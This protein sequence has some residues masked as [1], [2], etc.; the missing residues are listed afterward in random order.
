MIDRPLFLAGLNFSSRLPSTLTAKSSA[1]LLTLE[2]LLSLGPQPLIPPALKPADIWKV[3]QK[4]E[5]TSLWFSFIWALGLSSPEL[6]FAS[7]LSYDTPESLSC[8]FLLS[9]WA[10]VALELANGP[11]GR[12]LLG[13]N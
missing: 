3:E 5:F 10:H 4:D 11:Q 12:N 9:L 6:Q 7:P 13:L 2:P 8:H 1:Q